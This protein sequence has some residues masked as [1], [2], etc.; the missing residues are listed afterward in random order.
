MITQWNAPDYHNAGMFYGRVF[1]T[2][3]Q[4]R[5]FDASAKVCDALPSVTPLQVNG[6]A[7][8]IA[9]FIE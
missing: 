9:G 2:I 7:N 8:Y 5:A 1:N 3:I 6:S 4:M